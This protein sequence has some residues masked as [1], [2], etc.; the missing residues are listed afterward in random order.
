[1]DNNVDRNRK[2]GDERVGESIPTRRKFVW[3]FGVLSALSAIALLARSPFPGKRNII[4]CAPEK[5]K[6]VKMLT[7]DGVLVEVDASLLPAK[8]KKVTD[9]ELKNWIKS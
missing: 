6:M 8:G 4:S 5:K 2:T 9:K 7:Q 3:G 1:M